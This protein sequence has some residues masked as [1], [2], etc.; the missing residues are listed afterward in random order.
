MCNITTIV[1]EN[2][3][4]VIIYKIRNKTYVKIFDSVFE[5]QQFCNRISGGVETR[6]K[7]IG[8]KTGDYAI[9]THN[10]VSEYYM[11]NGN[12][13]SVNSMYLTAIRKINDWFC[14]RSA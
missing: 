1:K 12:P 5:M 4:A 3:I 9:L 6:F 2:K 10:T 8:V 13:Y 11:K 14:K 7:R